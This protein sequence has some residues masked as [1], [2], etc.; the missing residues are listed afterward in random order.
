MINNNLR[1]IDWSLGGASPKIL[2]IEDT[3]K[4]GQSGKFFAR[5]F[6][7]DIDSEILDW[8]DA[9]LLT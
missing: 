5:K 2:K 6:D 4:I 7:T 8:I 9:N 3:E 1:Y